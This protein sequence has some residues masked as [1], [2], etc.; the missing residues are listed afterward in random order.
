MCEVVQ[1]AID[2]MYYLFHRQVDAAKPVSLPSFSGDEDE[3]SC[4]YFLKSLSG[5][6]IKL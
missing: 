2:T 5:K 4:L 1:S 3:L 6:I